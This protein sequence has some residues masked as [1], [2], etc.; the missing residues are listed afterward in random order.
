MKIYFLFVAMLCS[1]QI[2]AQETKKRNDTTFLAPVEIL[3]IRAADKAPFTKTNLNKKDIDKNNLGQDLPFI[4]QQTPSVVVH[5]DA[6]N[7]V[8]YTG[9]RIRGTDATRINVTLNG[10]PYNDAESQGTFFVDMPD[11]ASSA[12]SIQIQRGV[13]TSSNGAGSFGGNI[14][15]ATN[16]VNK[17]FSASLNN[18]FGSFNTWKNTFAINSGIIGKNFTI[19]G[20]LSRINSNGYIDRATSDLKSFYV[21]TAYVTA[22]KSLRI[23]IF[24]GKEKT[25]QAWN[26]LP[27]NLLQT[28]RTYNPTGQEQPN[29]PYENETD[30][31]TQTHYQ[32]FYNQKISTHWAANVALFVTKGKGYYEQYKGSQKLEKFGLPDYFDGTGTTKKTDVVTRLWL[33]NIF[34]GTT[35]SFQYKKNKSE[36]A[37]GGNINQYDG[38][39]Y[40]NVIWAKVQ[41]AIP[42]NYRWYNLTAYKKDISLYTKWTEKWSPQWQTFLD[43]QFRKVNY[44]I[45]GFRKNPTLFSSNK[46][47]F[48]N[49]KL[50]LTYTNKNCQAYLSY[51]VAGKEPNREDFEAGAIAKPK[52]EILNDIEL[53]VEN[54]HKNFGYSAIIYYMAYKNQLILTGSVNDVGAYTR[55][56]VANSYRAGVELQ[57]N[58]TATKWLQLLGN[59]TFSNNRIKNFTEYIDDYDNGGQKATLYP[60]TTIAFS[61]S[62]TA[63]ATVQ[64]LPTKNSS[65]NFISKY[66]SRQYLDNTAN[67]NNSL[68]RY[69]LQDV[70]LN[71]L[72]TNKLFKSTNLIVQLN[73][74]LNK[75]YEPN[76][77][78]FSYI[79]GGKYTTENFY[80]P[81]AG[82]NFMFG[83][84]VGL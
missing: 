14:N 22:K 83:V 55:T 8:G 51:A 25:Y 46:F 81:M 10:I 69:F 52:P 62:I 30:N 40:G 26:G 17:V 3:A 34:Y 61:P 5:S 13:G 71:Y 41:A 59:V 31:Y 70:R 32:I 43:V 45:K 54:K 35:F 78:N 42:I 82:F 44:S 11:F 57:G 58:V 1:T 39:H 16:E 48:L 4:L 79:D 75:K 15:I 19:D 27:E 21:S 37:L 60:N 73:N 84:N 29:K 68:N 65:I 18:T 36:I 7:G 23:N 74:V 76:G 63:N 72:V 64:I 9:I 47:N 50:G 80:Y 28:N 33:D 49:P 77:Y 66:V 67:K 6:G 2:F 20:R 53:G 38:K 24:S 12:N 56:N